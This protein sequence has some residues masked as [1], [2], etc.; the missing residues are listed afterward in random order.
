M[1]PHAV[2]ARVSG[3]T[4]V[5]AERGHQVLLL[6]IRPEFPQAHP[7]GPPSTR[8]AVKEARKGSFDPKRPDL[9]F[10]DLLQTGRHCILTMERSGQHTFAERVG[11]DASSICGCRAMHVSQAPPL[12][13]TTAAV[14]DLFCRERIELLLCSDVFC[15]EVA[16]DATSK[17]GRNK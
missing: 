13:D 10:A 8:A 17:I 7:L 14:I 12:P 4:E 16:T 6:S 15:E 3:D 2:M 5:M 1:G 11:F 9:K